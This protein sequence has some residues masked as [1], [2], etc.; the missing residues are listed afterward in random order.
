MSELKNNMFLH[1]KWKMEKQSRQLS[2]IVFKY[3]SIRQYLRGQWQTE[4]NSKA[5]PKNS[6]LFLVIFISNLDTKIRANHY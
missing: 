1:L 5:R 4:N 6:S 3:P 2:N